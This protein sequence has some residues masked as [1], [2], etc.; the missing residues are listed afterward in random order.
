MLR[1][2][3]R[4]FASGSEVNFFSRDVEF[5]NSTQLAKFAKI[6]PPQ[7]YY[8]VYSIGRVDNIYISV[9]PIFF[10]SFHNLFRVFFSFLWVL[11]NFIPNVEVSRVLLHRAP[12]F[13]HAPYYDCVGIIQIQL[14]R[15]MYI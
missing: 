12:V 1:I 14:F 3:S 13:P 8:G 11:C 6:K 15:S 7:V 4:I 9:N 2:P 5:A 10:F